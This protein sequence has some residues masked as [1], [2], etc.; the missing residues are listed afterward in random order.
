[1]V[2]RSLPGL[3]RFKRPHGVKPNI[4]VK[5]EIGQLELPPICRI[6]LGSQVL[7][8]GKIR[9]EELI[10]TNRTY[11]GWTPITLGFLRRVELANRVTKGVGTITEDS[12]RGSR[13][14][15]HGK[16]DIDCFEY[17]SVASNDES[18]N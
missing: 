14:G 16:E 7:N 13:G 6:R 12:R 9:L 4:V 15:R 2:V 11:L 3:V 18:K 17:R 10:S 1:M 5:S 8:L